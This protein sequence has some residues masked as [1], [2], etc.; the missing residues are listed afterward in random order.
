MKDLYNDMIKFH[1]KIGTLNFMGEAGYTNQEMYT[2]EY[3]DFIYDMADK[4]GAEIYEGDFIETEENIIKKMEE[5]FNDV[6]MDENHPLK[7]SQS[8]KRQN[9]NTIEDVEE[10]AEIAKQV[11]IVKI[12]GNL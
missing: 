10:I 8:L 1:Q 9:K 7:L 2:N 12:A 3:K 5:Y 4:Y 11:L 6:I